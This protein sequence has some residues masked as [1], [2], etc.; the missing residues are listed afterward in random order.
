MDVLRVDG[1]RTRIDDD[2]V[3]EALWFGRSSFVVDSAAR[4]EQMLSRF[5]EL[6]EKRKTT[7]ARV[8]QTVHIVWDLKTPIPEAIRE[9]THQTR[10]RHRVFPL[11]LP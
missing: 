11:H 9:T 1:W 4:A 10:P 7:R 6:L 8:S 2:F 3:F 5:I